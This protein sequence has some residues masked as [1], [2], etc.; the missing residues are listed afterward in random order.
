MNKPKLT[1][2]ENAQLLLILMHV[3]KK[4]GRNITIKNRETHIVKLRVIYANLAI[5]TTRIP[6]VKIGVF[7]GL[8]DHSCIHHYEKLL[9]ETLNITYY[10][11]IYNSFLEIDEEVDYIEKIKKL[12]IKV[13]KEN[14]KLKSDRKRGFKNYTK[15][16][17]EN[18][19]AFRELSPEKQARVSLRMEAIIRME[20]AKDRNKTCVSYGN[21]ETLHA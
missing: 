20:N 21:W 5:K 10:K 17:N 15:K 18:E 2:Q 7:V 6:Y 9:E 8:R 1:E 4:S 14:K 11:K 3:Q 19:I 16:L 12:L 13:W